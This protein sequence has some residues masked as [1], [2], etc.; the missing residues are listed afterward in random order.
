MIHN[1]RYNVRPDKHTSAEIALLVPHE[2]VIVYD[3]DENVNKFWNGADWVAMGS[4][5][6]SQTLKHFIYNPVT[7][8][9]EADRAIETTLNSLFLGEQHKM[10]SGAENIFFTNLSTNTN[11]YSMKGGLKDQSITAN[12]GASGFIPPTGRVYSDMFSLPLGGTADPLTSIG[13]S[14]GNYFGVNIAGLGITT[15]AAEQVD[16][17]VSLEYTLQ[18]NGK[19]VYKQ[20]L[21]RGAAM[22]RADKTIYPNDT[23]EWFFDHPVEILAGTTIFA[24]IRK[25]DRTTDEDFGVFQVR[26]GDAI[27]ADGSYRYQ[28]IV[29]NRLFED[30]DLELI[31]PYL[32]YK[33]MDFGLEA[34]GSTVLL[35]DLSL[36]ADNV[37]VPHAVNT[38]EAIANGAEIQIKIKDG[39]KVL[40]ESLPVSG[41][42]INGS[43]VNSVLNQ[44]VVQLNGIFTNT[45]GFASGGGNPVSTFTLVGND[46][47]IGLEDNTSFT[48]DVTSLGVST[49]NFVSSGALNG[50]NLVLTMDDG[51]AIT[52]DASNMINGSSL[53]A[54]ND[55]WYFSYGDLANQEVSTPYNN[56][57][58]TQYNAPYYFGTEITKGSEFR[59]NMRNLS[60]FDIGIWDGAEVATQYGFAVDDANFSTAFNFNGG[61]QDGTNTDLKATQFSGNKYGVNHD[62]PVCIR[63]GNDGH[64]T[65]IDLLGGNEVVIAK[66]Q[67]PLA[68]DSFNMQL[69]LWQNNE[70]PNAFVTNSQNLWEMAHDFDNSEGGVFN[71]IED[72]TVI[73]STVTI[74]QGE[75]FMFDLD[76]I[77]SG[78]F[79]GTN[80]AGASSGNSL[81]EKQLTNSFE[82]KTNEAVTLGGSWTA[83]TTAA[84][85]FLTG[86]LDS[87]RVGGSNNK[88]GMFSLR[89]YLDNS[90]Q[91]WSE[92]ENELIATSLL[93]ADG[94]AIGFYMG[95]D[96][97]MTYVEIPTISKQ[98]IVQASQP[99]LD[100]APVVANQSVSVNEGEVLN[101]Q[102]VSS[103]NI[104]NQFVEVDAPSWVYLN[105][106]S[107]VLSGTAPSFLGT[108]ADTIVVTCKAGNAIGGTVDFTVT[109]SVTA[110]SSYTNTN[111]LNFNGTSAHLAGNP[112]LMNAMDR[113]TNGDGNAWSL[114]MWFKPSTST[115]TQTL[116]NYGKGSGVN[117]G[118]ITLHQTGGNNLT[119]QYGTTT[120]KI[121]IA[122]LNCL[123]VGAWNHLVVTFD[124]GTTGVNQADLSNYYSRFSIAV[125]GVVK[126]QYGSHSNYG[127]S[128]VL[129]GNDTSDN[130]FRI[131]RDNNVYNNYFDGVIN[132]VAIWNSNESANLAAIYNGGSAQDMSLLSSAPSHLYNIET[133]VTAISDS[134]GSANL[135]GYNFAASDLV[136]DAP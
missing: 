5:V 66:T 6:E 85:Y 34:T 29:H 113:A 19:K 16:M 42:S 99:I 57:G 77:G 118:A 52:I 63:F 135:S 105:Q 136:T 10:S 33:A 86:G 36:G 95:S 104:V 72:H 61:F 39:A 115:S 132:Q 78:E 84:N 55:N 56:G 92:T 96:E 20:I 13:Y 41:I 18:V 117:E 3:T 8:K 51:S 9:L 91:L 49:D 28:A 24:E 106:N 110:D 97:A 38:L 130:I 111:S 62:T 68:V 116:F 15:V 60:N 35:K 45:V 43:F 71:G 40:V 48:V 83:N 53:T 107:G 4:S 74:G 90:I 21:N 109:I 93:A 122:A 11:Y 112:T 121:V 37:L 128:G 81:A 102:I 59:W 25:I 47:T 22:T 1:T 31:S 73:R 44:A 58:I 129:N 65:L 120:N 114:S 14:G 7:D 134:I 87:W 123:T 30:K 70:F 108:A 133:S 12:Q 124:G 119:L 50:T 88:Q 54:V 27:Q 103:D 126:T 23:I 69:G 94:N 80:Y 127:Y 26:Q 32:K 76:R 67:I 101:Y 131:G 82:Y 125:D 17:G 89:Y 79:F 75:K 2:S 64:L 46:L 98:L 100:Y